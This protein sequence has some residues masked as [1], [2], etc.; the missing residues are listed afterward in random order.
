MTSTGP[1][2]EVNE[3]VG[4]IQVFQEYCRQ[5]AETSRMSSQHEQKTAE[6]Q[7][8]RPIMQVK[9]KLKILNVTHEL[10]ASRSN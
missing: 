5:K 10:V 1:E 8:T 6:Q 2:T 7:V 3:N 4:D 9:S